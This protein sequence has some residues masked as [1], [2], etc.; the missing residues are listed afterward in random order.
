MELQ[1]DIGWISRLEDACAD[2]HAPHDA[3]STPPRLSLLH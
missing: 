2:R 1:V 3:D